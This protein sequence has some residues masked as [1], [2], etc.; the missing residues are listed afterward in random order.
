MRVLI[1]GSAGYYG[2]ILTQFLQSKGVDVYGADLIESPYISKEKF[3]KIDLCSLGDLNASF[4]DVGFDVIINLATQIDFAAKSEK[5]LYVNNVTLAENLVEFARKRQVKTYIFTSS[6]SIFLGNSESTIHQF[7]QPLPVD[8]Y[9]RSKVDIET[10]LNGLQDKFNVVTFR[11]PNIIDSGRMGMLTVLFELLKNNSTIWVLDGGKI[12]HQCLYA[13]DLNEAILKSI[14]SAKSNTYN[15]GADHVDSFRDMF[16]SLINK[17]KSKSKIRSIPMFFALIALKA[18]HAVK[19]SPLGPYQFRMLTVPFEFDTNF[20]KK[21][22]N[23]MPTLSTSEIL[24]LAY[25]SY[26]QNLQ[27]GMQNL[28]SGANGKPMKMGVLSLLKYIKI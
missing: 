19:L 8:A 2:V 26:I 22:L 10:M 9:G 17:S 18:F 21:E 13:Q 5:E 11:C 16:I 4:P 27:A 28:P 14:Q 15:I 1:A 24:L 3:K 6:N 25:N 20:V 12:R 7:T 23:W